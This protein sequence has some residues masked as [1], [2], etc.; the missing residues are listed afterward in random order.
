MLKAWLIY[1]SSD[2]EKNRSFIEMHKEAG[3]KLEIEFRLLYAEKLSITVEN[4][5]HELRYEGKILEKPDFVLCRTR[6][7]LLTKQMELMGLPVFNNSEVSLVG[8]NKALAYQEAARL[9]IPVV[10]T[11]FCRREYLKE[12]LLNVSAEKNG[13]LQRPLVV[14]A[15]S[16]HG[17]SQVFLYENKNRL[18]EILSGIGKDDAVIQPK[19][20]GPGE[21]LRVY[22]IGNKIKGCVLRKAKEGFKSNFSLGGSVTSY[23]LSSEEKAVVDKLLERWHFDFAGID[24]IRDDKGQLLFNEIEDVVGSRMYYQ[25][26]ED[27]ILFDYLTYVKEKMKKTVY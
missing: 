18:E 1:G 19:V 5:E 2:A 16:G 20:S 10:D 4:S 23:M 8:N 11:C 15:V 13:K 17:G 26:Y 6:D 27:D 7:Y 22:I 12:K 21:D 3:K 9:S 25:C 24:F 14:K